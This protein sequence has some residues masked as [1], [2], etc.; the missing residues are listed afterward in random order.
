MIDG[1]ETPEEAQEEIDALEAA[2][3]SAPDSVEPVPA[4]PELKRIPVDLGEYRNVAHYYGLHATNN[5]QR[6]FF[7]VHNHYDN[8]K[9]IEI[10]ATTGTEIRRAVPYWA[11]H[12]APA[13]IACA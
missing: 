6:L 9:A 8:T 5:E 13:C 11:Y 1:L 7:N 12:G 4:T 3:P 2:Y 10:K